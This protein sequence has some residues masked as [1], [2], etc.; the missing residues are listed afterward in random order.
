MGKQKV[1]GSKDPDQ[2]NFDL[3]KKII[4]DDLKFNNLSREFLDQIFRK[5]D[6]EAKETISF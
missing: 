2:I 1:T 6:I 3:F 5:L 4:L